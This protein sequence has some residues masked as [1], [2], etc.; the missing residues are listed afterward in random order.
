[1]AKIVNWKLQVAN[2]ETTARVMREE[3]ARLEE[4]YNRWK[5]RKKLKVK[6]LKNM[7]QKT[8]VFLLQTWRGGR[9]SGQS[10]SHCGGGSPKVQSFLLWTFFLIYLILNYSYWSELLLTWNSYSQAWTRACAE[11]SCWCCHG[12]RERGLEILIWFKSAL[13]NLIQM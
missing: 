2:C 8:F 4:V 12:Q 11:G 3:E 13:P 6:I 7:K 1:M 10:C 9:E 5:E